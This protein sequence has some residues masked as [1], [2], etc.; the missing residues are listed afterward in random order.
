VNKIFGIGLSR[1]GT[2]S[3][4]AALQ[5]VGID[6]IHYPQKHQLFHPENDGV[7]D[8]PASAHY[9]ELDRR[10]PNS[11]FVYTIRDK[12]EWLDSIEKYLERKKDRVIS[13]WQ[14]ENRIAMYG[15]LD[16]NRGIFSA[17]YDKH[18][19]NVMD[20]FKGREPDLLILN[21]IGGDVVG[22]LLS[23]IH[24]KNVYNVS[25]FPH[26]NKRQ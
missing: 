17:M 26:E 14:K 11:K 1:T 4:S 12:E 7:C 18:D 13:P 22:K 15:Q 20:Y 16:F 19:Q 23:F 24:N 21:I 10:F 25:P 9:K 3:L 5:D 6:M 8:I 2:T